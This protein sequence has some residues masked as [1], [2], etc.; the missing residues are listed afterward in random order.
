MQHIQD[1][2]MIDDLFRSKLVNAETEAPL[3]L[4]Q[5]IEIQLVPK[6]EKK[7]P[8]FWLAAASILIAM[9]SFLFIRPKAPIYLTAKLP[10]VIEPTKSPSNTLENF[11]ELEYDFKNQNTKLL[12]SKNITTETENSPLL[13]IQSKKDSASLQPNLQLAR[14]VVKDGMEKSADL[15]VNISEELQ[16]EVS[17][18]DKM[19]LAETDL[20]TEDGEDKPQVETRK[21]IRGFGD[22]INF[23]VDKVDKREK[24]IIQFS[25]DDDQAITAVNIGFLKL[26]SKKQK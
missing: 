19:D 12:P 9:V 3:H 14:L 17:T 24:K 13:S 18:T 16:S 22:L 10:A 6:K 5:N 4:W 26:N 15:M 11:V 1:K 25:S 2:E 23:V 20:S 8:F 21:S 7:T